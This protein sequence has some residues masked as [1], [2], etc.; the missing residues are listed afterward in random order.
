MEV[1]KQNTGSSW[2]FAFAEHGAVFSPDDDNRLTFYPAT[3]PGTNLTDL[4]AA[5]L[6][7]RETSASYEASF[8]PY[9]YQDFIYRTV[10][11]GGEAAGCRHAYLC[12]DGLD[13]VCDIFLNGQKPATVE[14]AYI[15]HRFD[16]AGKLNSGANELCLIFRSP[17]LEAEKRKAAFD[18]EFTPPH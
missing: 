5:G 15:G 13:T 18:V 2:E 7:E 6:V 9:K 12:F 16:V 11:Q 4:Q 8:A 14:N 10:F 17:V 1:V 3:V